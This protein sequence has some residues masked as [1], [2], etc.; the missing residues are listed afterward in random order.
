MFRITTLVTTVFDWFPPIN[1]INQIFGTSEFIDPYSYHK[2]INAFGPRL[3]LSASIGG[4]IK[5]HI[6]SRHIALPQ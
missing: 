1:K 6:S 5:V 2:I 3:E 4:N